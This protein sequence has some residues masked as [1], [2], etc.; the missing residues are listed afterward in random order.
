MGRESPH[1]HKKTIEMF[2]H[3]VSHKENY[4]SSLQNVDI[5]PTN[6]KVRLASLEETGTLCYGAKRNRTVLICKF[7][8]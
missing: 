2:R 6:L 4:T 5:Q 1:R 3:N 8:S 7:K